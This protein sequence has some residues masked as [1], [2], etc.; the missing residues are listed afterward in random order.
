MTPQEDGKDGENLT[1]PNNSS[2]SSARS[3]RL[4]DSL[5]LVFTLLYPT[6]LT[7]LYFVCGKGLSPDVS[8]LCYVVG[9]SIQFA[10][11]VLFVALVLKERWLV[12]RFN[13][14][15]LLVGG[16]FGLAVAALIFFFGR[17]CMTSAGSFA[18]LF[19][20]LRAELMGRLE[21][22]G[23]DSL[24]PYTVLFFFYSIVHSGLEEY[25]WRWFAFGRIARRCS[26]LTAALIT[27]AA[28]MLHHVVLLGVY[29]GYDNL[30]TWV[31][32]F[33]VAV[34]GFV[35]QA[36]YKKTDSVYGGW[37]SHG[38]IDA[39]IFALGFLMLPSA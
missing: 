35:W 34:G 28:F 11:P 26:W 18:P 21:G 27:N 5:V 31:C 14:R 23:F 16:L 6:V 17:H 13:S 4:R 38:L 19:E 15:G 9:K 29:F 22:F 2:G 12:R 30:L 7:W 10:F 24:G 1:S 3:P 37:L 25:Y 32:S 33:G 8:K 20:R 39:G 36:I